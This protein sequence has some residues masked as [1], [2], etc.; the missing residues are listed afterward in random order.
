MFPRPNNPF[1]RSQIDSIAL[2]DNDAHLSGHAVLTAGRGNEPGTAEIV[3][4]DRDVLIPAQSL[5]RLPGVVAEGFQ[6]AIEDGLAEDSVE[7][8]L[9]RERDDETGIASIC[10]EICDDGGFVVARL[11]DDDL[12][13]AVLA[14]YSRELDLAR[15]D[16]GY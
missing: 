8:K 14:K 3:D 10:A 4:E 15:A 2:G 12:T 9:S 1:A 13:P 7:I 6:A 5:D 16:D 11:S